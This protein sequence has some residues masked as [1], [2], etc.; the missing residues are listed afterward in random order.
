[1][2]GSLGYYRF[3]AFWSS[4]VFLGRGSD[5]PCHLATC[6]GINVAWGKCGS[7]LAYMQHYFK[8]PEAC[9]TSCF[10][11]LRLSGF[12][13]TRCVLNYQITLVLLIYLCEAMPYVMFL[14]GICNSIIQKARHLVIKP[15][16]V[17]G[18]RIWRGEKVRKKWMR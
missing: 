12:G 6:L 5:S 17:F 18:S 11:F 8:Y 2:V 10:S 9:L 15:L 16:A 13:W 3:L 1:M 7:D 14:H 4:L